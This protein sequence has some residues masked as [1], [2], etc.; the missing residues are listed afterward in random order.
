MSRERESFAD[1]VNHL[2]ASRN[3]LDEWV[4]VSINARNR[5]TQFLS[6]MVNVVPTQEI[7][8]LAQHNLRKFAFVG[9][10]ERWND[11]IDLVRAMFGWTL[12]LPYE[13]L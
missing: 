5:M 13:I 10:M 2:L 7:F 11:T 9:L 1:D 4:K 8:E 3:T 12:P 6:G